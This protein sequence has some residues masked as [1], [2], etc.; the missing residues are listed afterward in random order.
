MGRA[1]GV[2]GKGNEAEEEG[3]EGKMKGGKGL[4]GRKDEDG[5]KMKGRQERR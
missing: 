5:R 4:E 3:R 1:K 2:G